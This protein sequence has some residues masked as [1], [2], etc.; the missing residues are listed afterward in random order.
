[1]ESERASLIDGH[2]EFALVKADAGGIELFHEA[3][4]LVDEPGIG[5]DD[6]GRR[7]DI[8][9][10]TKF[11]ARRLLLH[12]STA[13]IVSQWDA[14]VAGGDSYPFAE[15]RVDHKVVDMLLRSAEL[16]SGVSQACDGHMVTGRWVLGHFLAMTATTMEAVPAPMIPVMTATARPQYVLGT[17]SP[18][19]GRDSP[20]PEGSGGCEGRGH[21]IQRRGM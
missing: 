12:V 19:K 6:A 1:M 14:H 10:H 4:V 13:S 11:L 18:G 5:T 9:R 8:L 20:L 21:R 15:L 7:V 3:A 17:M 2:E 16:Q